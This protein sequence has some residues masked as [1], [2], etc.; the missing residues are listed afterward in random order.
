MKTVAIIGNP[1]VGK[2]VLFNELTGMK[3][4]VGNWPG[5]TVEKKTGRFLFGGVE[6]QVVDLPGTYSLTS[7]AKDELISR[8]FIVE[9]RPEVVV[10]IVDATNLERN[11]YLTLLLLELEANLVVALNRWDMARERR[12]SIDV[13]KL[14]AILESPVVP[15]VATTGEGLDLLK[16]AILAA[17]KGKGRK[18]DPAIEYGDDVEEAINEVE[19]A[20]RGDPLLSGYPTRWL[21]IKAL[22]GDGEVMGLLEA[23][24]DRDEIMVRV[25]R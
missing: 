17:S 14:S 9:E 23:S 11:L 12:I 19:E 4:H 20:I 13:E 16:E 3:Q 18:R 10:D 8:N 24:R 22:E 25:K 21:A 2:T 5:V 6:F 1:N 15:I 7:R